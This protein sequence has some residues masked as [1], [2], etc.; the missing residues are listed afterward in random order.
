M[1]EQGFSDLP[2]SL[3][4]DGLGFSAMDR[5]PDRVMDIWVLG[6]IEKGRM[7]L[8]IGHHEQVLQPGSYYLLP[9]GVRHRG[10]GRAAYAVTYWHF[11]CA[12]GLPPCFHLPWTG[13]IPSDCDTNQLMRTAERMLHQGDDWRWIAALLSGLLARIC[14][15]QRSVD[16]D[17]GSRTAEAVLSWLLDHRGHAW[18]R[19]ALE[20]RFGYSY[21]YL[22]RLFHGRFG[23]SIRTRH[24]ELRVQRAADLLATGM[25]I[26]QVAHQ[27]GFDDYFNFLR[28]FRSMKGMTAGAFRRA[29]TGPVPT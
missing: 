1:S 29:Q 4:L 20:R 11:R 7:P 3:V 5:H 12:T 16:A 26:K 23:C 19:A 8:A 15:H 9:P 27:A 21:R 10:L 25:T 22:N 28:R 13:A 6:T 24:L 17:D 18:D 2:A 14:S